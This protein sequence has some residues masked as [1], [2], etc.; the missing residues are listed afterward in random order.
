MD[1]DDEASVLRALWDEG[2]AIW[3]REQHQPAF[4]A[5]VAADYEAVY[6]Q[7]QALQGRVETF[8]EWGSGLGLITIMASRLGFDACGIE[9]Q[10]ALVDQARQ[11]A[12]RYAPEARFSVGS[13]IP[14]AYRWNP[15][16]GDDGSRT[17]FDAADGY[18]E[19][20]M[21][22]RDFD[23]IY[24]YPW[25]DEQAIFADVVRRHA[26]PAALF[27]SYDVREGFSL[28]PARRRR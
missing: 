7:L 12:S 13:F 26:A 25:P 19:L 5:F 8:L 20:D 10:P 3:E 27:L 2:S 4:E 24:V 23:L 17:D 21:E 14:D 16:F 6:H 9:I 11:L 1:G 15:E 28:N 22:L 18:G